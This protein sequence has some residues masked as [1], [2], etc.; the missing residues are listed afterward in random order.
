MIQISHGDDLNLDPPI[1]SHAEKIVKETFNFKNILNYDIHL[2]QRLMKY[3][4]EEH[5]SELQSQ[6]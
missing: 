6:D 1:S 4:S 3:R 2:I 5:T